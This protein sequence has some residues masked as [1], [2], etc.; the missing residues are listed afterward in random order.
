MNPSRWRGMTWALWLFTLLM[1]VA[2]VSALVANTLGDDCPDPPRARDDF[3]QE[4]AALGFVVGIGVLF[5]V[6]AL[7]FAA[8]NVAWFKTQPKRSKRS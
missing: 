4:A 2:I 3:C 5:C 6:S 1:G 8:L 7:G